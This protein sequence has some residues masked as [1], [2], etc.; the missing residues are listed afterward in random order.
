MTAADEAFLFEP[1]GDGRFRPTEWTRGPWSPDAQHGGPPAALMAHCCEVVLGAEMALTRLTVEL[2]RPVPLDVLR[3]ETRLFR[4]GR[5]IRIAEAVVVHE[6]SGA[7]VLAARALGVRRAEVALPEW[8]RPLDV[9]VPGPDGVPV[10]PPSGNLTDAVAAVGADELVSFHRDAVEH[11]FVG[12]GWDDLGPAAAWIHLR[13]GVVAG[14]PTTGAQRV[15]AAADFGSGISAVLDWSR[16][17]FINP[18]LSIHLTRPPVG[19]WVGLRSATRLGDV[20][21]GVCTTELWDDRGRVGTSTQGLL[22]EGD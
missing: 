18:D 8:P 4:D 15:A 22:V 2:M 1:L 12:G 5:K 11:R 3:V 6:A 17:R 14:E 7:E 16:Y 13:C 20:G 21:A 10:T 9:A 19:A